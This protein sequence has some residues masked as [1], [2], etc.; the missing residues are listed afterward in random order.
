M[1]VVGILL[2]IVG[3]AAMIAGIAGGIATMFREIRREH[4]QSFSVTDLPTEFVK[5]LTKLI[6]ALAA[7]PIWLALTAIG[8]GLVV[9]GGT[10]I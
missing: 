3:F 8:I 2:I 9:Y 4:E 7:A 5:A 6:Q 1:I 10:L